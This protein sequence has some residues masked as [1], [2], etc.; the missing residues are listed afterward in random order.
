MRRD[1]GTLF[2]GG[3]AGFVATGTMSAVMLAGEKERL[4]GRPSTGDSE[5]A[6]APC[7]RH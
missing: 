7:G 6:S 1:I 2:E 5:R 4:D 3:I